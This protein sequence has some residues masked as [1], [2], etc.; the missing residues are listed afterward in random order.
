MLPLTMSFALIL[1]FG[2]TEIS[3][4]K[5]KPDFAAVCIFIS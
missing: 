5:I 4:T 1:K 2:F 3:L